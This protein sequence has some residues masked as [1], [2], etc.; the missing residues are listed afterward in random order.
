M[1]TSTSRTY[2]ARA[3]E[4]R[5]SRVRVIK[6]GAVA[7]VTPVPPVA[8]PTAAPAKP[9]ARASVPIS[10]SIFPSSQPSEASGLEAEVVTV[11]PE[12]AQKWLEMGGPNRV[13][14]QST[15]KRYADAMKRGE[16]KLT[17]EAIKL[18][19]SQQVRDGQHRLWACF[20][21]GVPFT[22]MVVLNV[23]DDAFDVMDSGRVRSAADVLSVHKHQSTRQLAAMIR[24]AIIWDRDG[25][26]HEPGGTLGLISKPQHVEYLAAHP[27]L[28]EWVA[29]ARRVVKAG[30]P[31]ASSIF[32]LV[33]WRLSKIDRKDVDVFIEGLCTGAG[34]E[35]GD[36]ILALRNRLIQHANRG[37][38]RMSTEELA[39]LIIKAWNA[40]RRDERVNVLVFRR[41]GH[42]RE[43]FPE[44]V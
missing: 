8:T 16:W 21:S 14:H 34:L 19:A 7:P 13:I 4:S 31:G 17:G 12:M 41:S 18:S 3:D 33:F 27:D 11:T 22:T 9:T 20:D 43:R 44:A 5:N 42:G 30:L 36:A 40:W 24:N 26:P 28:E 29:P 39:A 25:Y 10:H 37:G 35:P 38:G 15:V 23:P 2:R 6:P 1:G 32:S